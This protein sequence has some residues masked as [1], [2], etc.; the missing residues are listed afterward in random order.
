MSDPKDN[1][2]YQRSDI[3][4]KGYQVVGEQGST[5]GGHQSAE[6][7]PEIPPTPP[8]MPTDGIVPKDA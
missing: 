1:R 7:S 6:D 2:G 3:E 8:A 5:S 4:E